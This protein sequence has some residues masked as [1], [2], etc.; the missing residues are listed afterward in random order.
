MS[1][2]TH[3]HIGAAAISP[4]GVNPVISI[5]KTRKGV[6]YFTSA[7]AGESPFGRGPQAVEIRNTPRCA[8]DLAVWKALTSRPGIEWFCLN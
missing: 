8:L 7:V 3:S 4:T 5:T 1:H 2:N 6:R